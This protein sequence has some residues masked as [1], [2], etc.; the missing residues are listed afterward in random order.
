[1]RYRATELSLSGNAFAGL[2]KA[3][4]D[5][6]AMFRFKAEGFSMSPFIKNGDVV[7]VS[8]C[9]GKSPSIGDVVAFINPETEKAVVHRVVGKGHN[10]YMVRGDNATGVDGLFA[11]ENIL[12]FVIRVERNGDR[13]ILGLGLEK[14]LIAALSRGGYLL[15]LV[16]MMR[17]LFRKSGS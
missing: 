2:L 6:N 7:T 13:V 11:G 8:P 17:R 16:C 12:G 5:K 15:P 4:L 14:Y 1:M 3:V 10:N 9:Y